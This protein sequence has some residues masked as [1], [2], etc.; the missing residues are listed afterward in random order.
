MSERFKGLFN[1]V[2]DIVLITDPQG[3]VLDANTKAQFLLGS[4]IE[5]KRIDR[6][7]DGIDEPVDSV[8]YSH[9]VQS[10]HVHTTST[11]GEKYPFKLTLVPIIDGNTPDG[12]IVIGKELKEIEYYRSELENLRERVSFLERDNQMIKAQD[13]GDGAIELSSALQKLEK[14]NIRLDEMNKTLQKELELASLVQKSLVPNLSPD[15]EYLRMKFH[16]E[17]MGPVGG[18]YY[19]VIDLGNGKNGII[20]ADVSGHGVSSAFIAAMLKIS[21]NNF[22]PGCVSPSDLLTKLNTEYCRLIK[23]GDYVT[24]FYAIFDP[25]NRSLTYS[26]AGHPMPLFLHNKKKNVEKLQSEG[27][28][29]GMFDSADYIDTS[30]D[31]VP[32]DRY[33]VYTDGIIEAYSDEQEEQ[34][35][36]QRLLHCYK[37]YCEK[38]IGEMMDS[39]ISEVKLFMQKSVFYDDLSIVAVEYKNGV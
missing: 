16:Y 17:P 20:V 19:D 31:F 7:I 26:G 15:Q 12:M 22:A 32:G 25:I 4:E 37:K 24:A 13:S 21:F 9:V 8:L 28:F 6:L 33:L 23:T 29:L 27:F 35:G 36:I 39:I 30:I 5:G 10:F 14:A 3:V 11:E 34:F 18:D 1:Y 2:N 38:T